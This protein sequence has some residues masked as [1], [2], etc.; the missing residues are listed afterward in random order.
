[1]GGGGGGGGGGGKK[2]TH[3]DS[4]ANVKLQIKSDIHLCCT[5]H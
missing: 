2:A 1:M 4:K 3:N 5:L